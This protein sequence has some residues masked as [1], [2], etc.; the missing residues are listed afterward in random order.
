MCKNSMRKRLFAVG[1]SLPKVQDFLNGRQ[2]WI[3]IVKEIG[4]ISANGCIPFQCTF[5]GVMIPVACMQ[6][7]VRMVSGVRRK[8][9]LFL[10]PEI[11]KK[12]ISIFTPTFLKLLTLHETYWI[13]QNKNCENEKNYKIK[14]SKIIIADWTEFFRGS[15]VCKRSQS[16]D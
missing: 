5:G 3:A 8:P 2:L 4:W 1:M 6:K 15:S 11:E 14:I 10:N 9:W 12:I 16:S 13:Q 7:Q